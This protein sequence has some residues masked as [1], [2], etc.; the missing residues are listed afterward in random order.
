MNAL[1]KSDD[2]TA[3]RTFTAPGEAQPVRR[4]A[5]AKPDPVEA[6]RAAL[7]AEIARLAAE[8]EAARTA[9]TKAVAEA[10]AEGRREGLTAADKRDD[11]RLELLRTGIDDAIAAF[12]DR[13]ETLDGLAPQLV[14][15]ALGKMFDDSG[16]WAAMAE[17]MLAKQLGQLRRSSVVVVRVSPE[18]FADAA[19]LSATGLRVERDADLRAG[20]CAIECKLGQIDLDVRDQWRALAV[21][22]DS[23]AAEA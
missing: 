4:P 13:L 12:D 11:E 21:L 14:R 2:A 15:A 19:A 22:L 1:I 3:I 7:R 10:R 8:L 16:Q 9:T 17:A 6:E 20:A 23:M 5:P 18:D